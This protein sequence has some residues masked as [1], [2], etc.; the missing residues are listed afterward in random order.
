MHPYLVIAV[1]SFGIVMLFTMTLLLIRKSIYATIS[2]FSW[3]RKI[4]VEKEVLVKKTSYHGFPG[5]SRNRKTIQES[6]QYSTTTYR[7][8]MTYRLG[9]HEW[10][11][12]PVTE[13]KWGVRTRYDFEVP[14]WQYGRT[15]SSTGESRNDV[16]WPACILADNE[17]S[18]NK[19][20][21]YTVQF[22]AE[23]GKKYKKRLKENIWIAL[24]ASARY[25]LK[26][27]LF[28]KVAKIQLVQADQSIG[29]ELRN[30]LPNGMITN[31]KCDTR[32]HEVSE[33][34]P[35]G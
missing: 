24:D 2:S 23:N 8:K 4:N 29:V 10:V 7:S 31:D 11:R 28:G 15:I 20:E 30:V 14:E 5:N 13:W 6:Y 32:L 33:G 27:T 21:R 22:L 12:E 34:K 1:I 3:E 9:K 19:R 25:L 35:S 17:R 16:H 26:T 18:S